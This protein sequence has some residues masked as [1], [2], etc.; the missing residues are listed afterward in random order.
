MS[1]SDGDGCSDSAGDSAIYRRYY[2]VASGNA[3]RQLEQETVG[4]DWGG[5]GYTT[6]A[7]VDELIEVLALRPEV[8][9]VDLGSGAGWPGLFVAARSGCDVVLTDLT[10]AGMEAARQRADQRSV[11]NAQVVVAASERVPFAD[12]SFDAVS[13]ADLLC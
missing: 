12:S 7:Q 4:T 1:G 8:Q 13:H 10:V 11:A 6:V 9:Y 5:N 3:V 2:E